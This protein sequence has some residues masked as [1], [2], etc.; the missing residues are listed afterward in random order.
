MVILVVICSLLRLMTDGDKLF[1]QHGTTSL[2]NDVCAVPLSPSLRL[3]GGFINIRKTVRLFFSVIYIVHS[4]APSPVGCLVS[5]PE[6]AQARNL[7]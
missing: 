5:P 1:S 2:R 7:R 3:L 4:S 6:K